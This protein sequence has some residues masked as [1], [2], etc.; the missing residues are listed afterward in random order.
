M[1]G[2][3]VAEQRQQYSTHVR[4]VVRG[5][6]FTLTATESELRKMRSRVC[7]WYDVK[8]RGIIGSGRRARD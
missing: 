2:S 5:D 1:T 3:N 8:A 4:V 7:E 6:D